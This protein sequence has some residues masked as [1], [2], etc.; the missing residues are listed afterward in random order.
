MANVDPEMEKTPPR[1]A[2]HGS[3]EMPVAHNSPVMDLV[4]RSTELD[5]MEDLTSSLLTPNRLRP[6][7]RDGAFDSV[8]QIHGLP[9]FCTFTTGYG[10]SVG[11]NLQ[12]EQTDERMGFILAPR[13]TARMS[14]DGREYEL[15]DQRGIAMIAGAPRTLNYL[16]DCET[17]VL[18]MNMRKMAD[19]CAKLLACDLDR[20]LQFDTAF[21]LNSANGQSWV[22]LFQYA[23]AELAN[24][25]S[26]FRT[27]AAARQ[28]LEQTVL[29]GFLLSQTH[30]YS[31]A[32]LRPQSAAVPFYVKRAEAFIEAH[33]SEPL[34]LAD[35][36]AHAGVSA[37]SLQNGFQNFRNATPM[38]FLRSLR[39]KRAYETLLLS[40]PGTVTV[41]EIALACGFN[42]MGEF[43]SLYKRTFGEAPRQTLA[44]ARAP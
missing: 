42:H 32:L 22:R 44:R 41:T 30:T 34:S 5:E 38:G 17:S 4:I 18:V 6:L 36:A 33:F 40:D 43:A 12:Y 16:D 14:M 37:R 28:Q 1:E 9:D 25:H 8:F 29:T 11:V 39:L 10:C 7:T 19:F 26:L 21:D 15:S 3:G 24:P 13:G 2:G 31:D 23:T 20:E 35:I 27:M